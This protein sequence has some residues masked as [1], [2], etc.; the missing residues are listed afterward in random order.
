MS[1]SFKIKPIFRISKLAWLLG[2]FYLLS[3]STAHA[4]L[5]YNASLKNGDYG[6]GF[7]VDTFSSCNDPDG[8]SCGDGDLSN[9]GI[10]NTTEGVSYTSSN[11][12]INFS[13]G[14]DGLGGYRQRDFRTRGTVSVMFKADSSTFTSGQLFTDNYGFN[15]YRTGQGTNG[16]GLGRLAGEDGI[17]NT[18]DDQI[19]VGWSTWNSGTWY[20]HNSPSSPLLLNLDE[21][22]HIGF[23]WGGPGDNFEIW[24]DGELRT[25]HDTPASGLWGGDFSIGSAYNFALGEIHERAYGN[26]SM[27]GITFANLEIWDEYRALGATTAPVPVPA[28]FSLFALGLASLGLSKKKS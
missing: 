21:W 26:S 14:K 7:I 22:H 1:N 18:T 24:V 19:S 6:A 11:A 5:L 20:S 8:S 16:S 3:I 28:A 10:S 12:A 4:A 27:Y 2:G 15:Q 23:A 13:L 9:I 17:L 25:S